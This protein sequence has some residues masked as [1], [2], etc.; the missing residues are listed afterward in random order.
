MVRGKVL[1]SYGR[2]KDDHSQ[3]HARRGRRHSLYFPI[4]K[5]KDES[6]PVTLMSYFKDAEA[7]LLSG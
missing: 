5:M 7:L 4:V 1:D 6:L 2:A 3:G